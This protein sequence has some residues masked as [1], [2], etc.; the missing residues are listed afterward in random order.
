MIV[1]DHHRDIGLCLAHP[2][3][4]HPR[5][6]SKNGFQS[7][8]SARPLSSA[9]PIEGTWLVPS[10]PM[11]SAIVHNLSQSLSQKGVVVHAGLRRTDHGDRGRIDSRD[12]QYEEE[13]AAKTDHLM[14]VALP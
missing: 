10:P 9:T 1:E 3:P 12:L 7:A 5:K 6:P 11:I 2:M 8:L 14:P 4:C 13:I